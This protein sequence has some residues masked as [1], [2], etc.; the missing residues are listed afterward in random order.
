LNTL[1]T[2]FAGSIYACTPTTSRGASGN[3]KA[4][5]SKKEGL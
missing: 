4:P 5:P 3:F 2:T 1:D